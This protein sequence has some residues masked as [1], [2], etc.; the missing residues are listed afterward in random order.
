MLVPHSMM[1][2]RWF[3]HASFIVPYRGKALDNLIKAL[4]GYDDMYKDGSD[5]SGRIIPMVQ[6]SGTGKSKLMRD[7]AFKVWFSALH[8]IRTTDSTT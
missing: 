6:S 7:L 1:Q 8:V 4:P 3:L 2:Q 5:L